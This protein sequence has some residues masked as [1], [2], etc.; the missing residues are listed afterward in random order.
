MATKQRKVK[1]TIIYTEVETEPA[2]PKAKPKRVGVYKAK[3]D[4][5]PARTPFNWAYFG[6]GRW[7]PLVRDPSTAEMEWAV[8]GVRISFGVK[9]A[10]RQMIW[11]GV[12]K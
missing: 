6:D 8:E 4:G 5:L 9:L 11:K 3:G 12:T 1:P 7:G 2:G 10:A